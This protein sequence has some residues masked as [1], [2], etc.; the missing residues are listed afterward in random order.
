M[1]SAGIQNAAQIPVSEAGGRPASEAI[2]R[3]EKI[4]KYYAQPSQNR[5][6]VISPT[7]LQHCSRRDCGAP[8]AVRLG[9]IDDAADAFR[10]FQAI[11]RAGL[12][13]RKAH[14]RDAKSTFRSSS[15]A[16]R[17]FPGS[18]CWRT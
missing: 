5:I 18:R 15:R 1:Q 10:A 16:S 17:C 4:E 8:R 7:D 13:A 9:Q 11:G 2:I 6:Q 12:L 3:A 14:R